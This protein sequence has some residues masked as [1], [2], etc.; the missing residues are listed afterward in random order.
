MRTTWAPTPLGPV[1]AD[2]AG[3]RIRRLV[4]AGADPQGL[5]DT[6]L[7]DALAGWF[8]TGTLTAGY[9]VDALGGAFQQRVWQ[10]VS[11]LVRG[12]TTTYAGLAGALGVPRGARAVARALATNPVL[13]LVPCHR[14]IGADG[15]LRG[16]AGGI[17]R[18]RALLELEGALDG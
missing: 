16:Y 17:A 1:V 15:S 3:T 12:E 11:G 9:A 2:L 14:V 8:G 18:K 4:F 6:A 13:L 5:P 7:E 10:A